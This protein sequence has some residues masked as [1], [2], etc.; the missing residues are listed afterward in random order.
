MSR[1]SKTET[2]YVECRIGLCVGLE[3]SARTLDEAVE[4]AKELKVTDAVDILGDNNDCNFT[5]TGV[6][7]S[8]GA[9]AV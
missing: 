3:I 1:P 5:I 2:Y 9:P 8:G 4:K 6:F 7:K